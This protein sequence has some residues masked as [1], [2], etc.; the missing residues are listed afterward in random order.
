[1]VE[2]KQGNDDQ[3]KLLG[4]EA[5]SS[6]VTME[7]FKKRQAQLAAN[8]DTIK[9]LE[10]EILYN[11]ASAENIRK[12]TREQAALAKESAIAAFGKEVLET[13]DALEKVCATIS[14]YRTEHLDISP[15]II[16][17]LDGV[18]LSFKVILKVLKRHGVERIETVIGTPFDSALHTTLFTTQPSKSVKAGEVAEVVK[19]GYKRGGVT[20][21]HAEVGVAEDPEN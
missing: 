20:L 4:E 7:T 6:E 12:E 10:K 9:E 5:E 17:V 2:P 11:A 8:A 21:R 13:A 15:Q 18:E 16:S 3:Q 19:E 14:S 1:M